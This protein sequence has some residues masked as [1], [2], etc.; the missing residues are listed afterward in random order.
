MSI[1]AIAGES[2]GVPGELA[3]KKPRLQTFL[4]TVG[5][6]N[7]SDLHLKADTVPRV[8]IAG[9]LKVL[10][11]E[12]LS[13]DEIEAMVREILTPAQM[14]EFMARGALDVAYA[15]TRNERFRINIFKQ[16]GYTSLAARRINPRVPT[17]AELH[18]PE[19]LTRVANVE[20]GLVLLAGITGSGKSTTIASMIEQINENK[21][22]HIVTVEDPIEFAFTD[23]K[24]F[25]NQREVGLDCE[26]YELAIRS[27][28]REDPDVIL[29]GEMRDRNTVMT[30]IQAAETGH[31]V[32]STIHASSAS[33][34]ITRIL[35]LFPQDQHNQIRIALSQNIQGIVYQK[36]VPAIDPAIRRVPVVEVLLQS[37][38]TRK[39]IMEGRE[40]ELTAVIRGEKGAGM[41]DFND[42]LTE[43]VL[44]EVISSK[45]ALLA[46]PN[47]DELKMRMK[48]IKTNT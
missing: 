44:K 41:I 2:A 24:A 25:I 45:E 16:R 11:T 13:N 14:D 37:P 31:L 7:G 8:R 4:K 17:Y 1:P 10:K 28:M 3:A 23:K 32:F 33:G 27:L 22:V 35:E 21:S 20:Q 36:L 12:A 26:S 19:V 9:E 30:A 40:T 46:S 6:V 18:L 43:L 34:A 47:P 15:I 42:M 38:N 29:I 39:Y 48:G 5:A